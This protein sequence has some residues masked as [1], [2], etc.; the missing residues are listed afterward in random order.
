[1][2][3]FDPDTALAVTIDGYAATITSGGTTDG[4]TGGT[5]GGS[6]V[7]TFN[8]PAGVQTNKAWQV[9]SA[10]SLTL[11]TPRLRRDSSMWGPL[12]RSLPMTPLRLPGYTVAIS[13]IQYWAG[14]GGWSSIVQ[15]LGNPTSDGNRCWSERDLR[16][17]P[18]R[19]RQSCESN[20]TVHNCYCSFDDCA[21]SDCHALSHWDTG[22]GDW[23]SHLLHE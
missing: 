8:V 13:S 18:V 23:E 1:M 14:S 20:D 11:R 6:S 15:Q 3:G 16:H 10:K 7:V 9:M 17:T 5:T 21:D 4:V 19:C 2:S 22:N 12:L